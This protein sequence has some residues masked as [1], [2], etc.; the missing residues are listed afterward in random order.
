MWS[1]VSITSTRH[2]VDGLFA[3]TQCVS[4]TTS[5]LRHEDVMTWKRFPH[6]CPFVRGIHWLS[7]ESPYKWA[8]NVELWCFSLDWTIVLMMYIYIYIWH[9]AFSLWDDEPVNKKTE[10]WFADPLRRV[11]LLFSMAKRNKCTLRNLI[12]VKLWY[13]WISTVVTDGLVMVIWHQDTS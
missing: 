13:S 9:K 10:Y 4:S 5:P 8:S 2:G 7:V 3:Q 11:F 6:Y 1:N 12:S